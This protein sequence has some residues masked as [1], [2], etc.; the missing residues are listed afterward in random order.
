MDKGTR[1]KLIA[2]SLVFDAIIVSAVL[3]YV[4]VHR[5]EQGDAGASTTPAAAL[6][7]LYPVPPFTFT[8]QDNAP[9]SNTDLTGKVWIAYV[10]FSTCAGPCPVMNANIAEL[11][12]S[13]T[14]TSGV[15]FVGFTVDPEVDTPATLKAYGER[16]EAD[17]GEWNLLTGDAD[18][19]QALA[20]DG[21]K[22]GSGD[23]PLIHSEYFV[24]VDKAG[25]IRGYFTGTDAKA[26]PE[27]KSALDL[28]LAE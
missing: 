11:A 22:L 16:Y 13:Y 10:F 14:P 21:F 6:Q 9:V 19:L 7:K 27:V 17:F 26:L 3:W 8:N 20:R 28:L 23:S 1:W 2:I 18:K 4:F 24:L 15:R 5:A 25:M 12:K